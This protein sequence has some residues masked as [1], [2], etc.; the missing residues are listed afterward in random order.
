MAN[1][2]SKGLAESESNNVREFVCSR[3][4]HRPA[5]MMGEIGTCSEAAVDGLGVT[6]TAARDKR[7]AGEAVVDNDRDRVARSLNDDVIRRMAGLGL[8]LQTTAEMD[9]D[10]VTGRL[11]VAVGDLDLTIADVRSVVFDDNSLMHLGS[12]DSPSNLR[13]DISW[14]VVEPASSGGHGAAVSIRQATGT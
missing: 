1:N 3:A 8:W 10:T 12:E 13:P 14:P 2:N 4:R 7:S 5:W 6:P 9:D 11:E